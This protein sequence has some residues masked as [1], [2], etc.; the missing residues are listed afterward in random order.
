MP[1]GGRRVVSVIDAPLWDK[2]HWQAAAYGGSNDPRKPPI[3]A[4]GFEDEEAGIEIFKRWRARKNVTGETDLVRIA[5]PTGID[6]SAPYAH[7]MIIGSEVSVEVAR[8]SPG[9]VL[10]ISRILHT[11]STETA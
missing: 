1:H 7:T 6:K 3:L 4:L 10:T 2:A 9:G 11:G 5:I 8:A